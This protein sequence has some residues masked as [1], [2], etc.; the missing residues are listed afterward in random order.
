[1]A[2]HYA[3]GG[4]YMER[5]RRSLRVTQSIREPSETRPRH[6]ELHIAELAVYPMGPET[7][8]ACRLVRGEL[9]DVEANATPDT[10]SPT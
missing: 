6:E 2:D 10:T 4:I 5:V 9:I 1:M 3:T 7:D 8:L